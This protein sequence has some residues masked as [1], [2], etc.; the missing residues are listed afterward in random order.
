MTH[1]LEASRNGKLC[2]GAEEYEDRMNKI[3]RVVDKIRYSMSHT[4]E[5]INVK[6]LLDMFAADSGRFIDNMP[7]NKP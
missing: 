7:K 5:R 3:E 1:C 6:E 4:V 2:Q